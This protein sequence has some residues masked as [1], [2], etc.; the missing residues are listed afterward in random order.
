MKFLNS[1]LKIYLIVFVGVCISSFTYAQSFTN[2]PYSSDGFGNRITTNTAEN[3]ALGKYGT[4]FSSPFSLNLNNPASYKTI[5]YTTFQASAFFGSDRQYYKDSTRNTLNGN[6]NFGSLAFPINKWIGAGFGFSPFSSFGYDV[7]KT[8]VSFGNELADVS[9]FGDGA[10]N[11]AFGGVG[12]NP[13]KIFSDSILPDFS[14]GLSSS[15]LFGRATRSSSTRFIG[16]DTSGLY[17]NQSL[18]EN[19]Y[20]GMAM[21]YGI[22]NKFKLHKNLNLK[23]GISYEG[24]I[25]LN[26]KESFL[27][28]TTNGSSGV[29]LVLADS[30]ENAILVPASYSAGFGIVFK[31]SVSIFFDFRMQ[32]FSQFKY[33]QN[34]FSGN[35]NQIYSVGLQYLPKPDLKGNVLQRSVYRLGGYTS[36]GSYKINNVAVPEVGLSVGF[37]LSAKYQSPPML[38]LAFE[39]IQ[40]GNTGRDFLLEKFYRVNLGITINDRWFLKRKID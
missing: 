3:V 35:L 18:K 16:A 40:R 17:L 11:K 31:E 32:D 39:Y 4:S 24:K 13:F 23:M 30:L 21:V 37:G 15:F 1:I 8:N 20:R 27:S 7:K 22:Q 14:I 5:I 6:F 10:I 25:S 29:L 28:G 34:N 12:I 33:S 38:N 26:N 19:N 9:Y 36:N 2:T